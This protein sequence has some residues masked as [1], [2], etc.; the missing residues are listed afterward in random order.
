[1]VLLLNITGMRGARVCRENGILYTI[2]AAR[3]ETY[4]ERY[5]LISLLV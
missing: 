1:M 2:P 4:N 3:A 5:A